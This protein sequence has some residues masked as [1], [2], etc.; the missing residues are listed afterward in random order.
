MHYT[1]CMKMRTINKDLAK[2]LINHRKV[3]VAYHAK[4]SV[5]LL[6]RICGS[7]RINAPKEAYGRAISNYLGVD[8]DDLFPWQVEEAS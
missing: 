3:D 7:S 8:Y 6:E 2:K 4:C 5:A 1:A